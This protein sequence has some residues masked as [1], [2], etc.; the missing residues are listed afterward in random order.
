MPDTIPQDVVEEDQVLRGADNKK[1]FKTIAESNMEMSSSHPNKEDTVVTEPPIAT[2]KHPMTTTMHPMTTTKHP[3]TTTRHPMTTTGHPMTTTRPPVVPKPIVNITHITRPYIIC[4]SYWEQQSNAILNMFSMQRWANS[5]GMTVVEPF[6]CQSELKFPPEVLYNNTLANTL[7]LRDYIDLDYW[8]TQAKKVGIPPLESWE[9]FSHQSA[10]KIIL[11]IL[12]YSGA[13]GTYDNDKIKNHPECNKAKSD[14]FNKHGK[15][16]HSLQFEVIRN[17]CISFNRYIIPPEKFNADLQIANN[18]GATVWI[19]EWQG[20]ENG[21]VAFTGLGYNKFGRTFDGESTYLAM[22]KPSSRLLKDSQ[23]Y[24]NE[25][26]VTKFNQ[27]DAVVARNKPLYSTVDWYVHHFN[28]C[29]SQLEKHT[30]S[31]KNKM[32]LAIDMGRFGDMVRA[33][34]FDYN[35]QGKYTGNGKYLYQRY[36]NVVYGSKSIDSYEND[37]VRVTNG[38]VDS[39]YIGALQRTIALHA[40]HVFVVGGHSA[41]QRILIKQFDEQKKSNAVTKICFN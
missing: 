19:T 14:F 12:P 5:L 21:R 16:F 6:V 10:K 22:I 1:A 31:V 4:S 11:V 13:G 33:N 35:S 7:R 38:I 27:F 20:V 32:F 41:F 26:L 23:R 24:V 18:K 9:N 36:L 8:N 39:G 17:V 29:V 37:F 3:M 34:K 28:D 30:R 25:V 15:V 2:T 40:N